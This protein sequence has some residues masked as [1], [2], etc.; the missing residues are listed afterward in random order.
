V[1]SSD[2]LSPSR[3]KMSLGRGKRV[4]PQDRYHHRLSVGNFG[5]EDRMD[6]T[7]IGNVVNLA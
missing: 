6:Y 7:I 1:S 3:S 2:W 4:P 5:S